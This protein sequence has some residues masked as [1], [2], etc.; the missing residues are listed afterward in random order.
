[1]AHAGSRKRRLACS[2]ACGEGHGTGGS[3]ATAW[4]WI[5]MAF[6]VRSFALCVV[7]SVT[8]TRLGVPDWLSGSARDWLAEVAWPRKA[9]IRGTA[10]RD[11]QRSRDSALTPA[12][13]HGCWL[14]ADRLVA[15]PDAGVRRGVSTAR[16]ARRR[17]RRPGPGPVRWRGRWRGHA[18]GPR[19]GH[20]A[21]PPSRR[22]PTA[23]AG[24][25]PT[26]A[27]DARQA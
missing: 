11:W 16:P 22:C 23:A 19:A 27:P 5:I 14:D 9:P 1:M 4:F 26:A 18:P 8:A 21:R 25:W 13:W 17:C 2:P 3:D 6:I 24:R 20:R 7:R 12:V 15:D 10:R